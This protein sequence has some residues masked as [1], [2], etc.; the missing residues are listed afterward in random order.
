MLSGLLI[1]YFTSALAF[2]TSNSSDDDIIF[3]LLHF[4]SNLLEIN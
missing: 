4:Q 3:P 2:I 1:I